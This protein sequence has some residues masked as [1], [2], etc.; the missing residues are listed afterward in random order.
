MEQ[1]Q[2]KETANMLSRSH[3]VSQEGKLKEVQLT[4]L[5]TAASHRARGLL[6]SV[7]PLYNRLSPWVLQRL[8]GGFFSA[9]HPTC[10]AELQENSQA[11]GRMKPWLSLRHPSLCPEIPL[12][13]GMIAQLQPVCHCTVGR[14]SHHLQPH[15]GYPLLSAGGRDEYL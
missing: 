11:L 2:P 9:L 5:R 14:R 10:L 6:C 8:L 4:L 1:Q 15:S 7:A 3:S 13:G 12:S